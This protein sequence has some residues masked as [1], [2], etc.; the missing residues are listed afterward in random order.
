M[1]VIK[2]TVVS[3]RQLLP[4]LLIG[5][6]A[7]GK[8]NCCFLVEPVG[9]F[10]SSDNSQLE[11]ITFLTDTFSEF[12]GI[13]MRFLVTI[14]RDKKKPKISLVSGAFLQH[15][16]K[17]KFNNP[18]LANLQQQHDHKVLISVLS[19]KWELFL[20][21]AILVYLPSVFKSKAPNFYTLSTMTLFP[22]HFCFK[23]PIKMVL[24]PLQY[25]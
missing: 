9:I 1:C 16:V 6:D 21:P 11:N 15:V 20:F 8:G 25:E 2:T 7:V 18:F 4:S 3:V 14:E 5:I 23:S 10:Q 22:Y 13:G 17:T 24:Q 12:L 19:R